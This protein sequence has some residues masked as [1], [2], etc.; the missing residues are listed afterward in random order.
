MQIKDDYFGKF[1]QTALSM[2]TFGYA[3]SNANR[4]LFS[5]HNRKGEGAAI[6]LYVD[7]ITIMGNDKLDFV[8]LTERLS[9]QLHV[10]HLGKLTIFMELNFSYSSR[11]IVL[12][13]HKYIFDIS[14]LKKGIQNFNLLKLR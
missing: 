4:T 10:I 14:F 1:S 6:Q 2:K 13:Q 5:K 7:D 9:K 8:I 3:P 11:G 12:S